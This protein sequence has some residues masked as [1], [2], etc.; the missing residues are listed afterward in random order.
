[1]GAAMGASTFLRTMGMSLGT[2]VLGT[3]YTTRLTNE[4]TARAGD[5]GSKLVSGGAQLPPAMLHTLPQ[6][7]QDA[8]HAAVT[9][10]IV[11]V[12]WAGAAAGVIGL[13]VSFF[14]RDVKLVGFADA[15]KAEPAESTTVG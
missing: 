8:L 10:G 15:P 9:H 5:A 11:G 7:L 13:I 4:L 14:I 3:V 1:M 12:F 6:P 2:A